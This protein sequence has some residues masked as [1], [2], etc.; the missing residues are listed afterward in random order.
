MGTILVSVIK[1]VSRAEAALAPMSH[2]PSC[3]NLRGG[4]LSKIVAAADLKACPLLEEN[5]LESTS[6]F[7]MMLALL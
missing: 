5:Y 7:F 6:L 3:M 1:L 2:F 4:L